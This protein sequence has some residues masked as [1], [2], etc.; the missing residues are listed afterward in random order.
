MRFNHFFS[1]TL[2]AYG[3]DLFSPFLLLWLMYEKL[4]KTFNYFCSQPNKITSLDLPCF[5]TWPW[6]VGVVLLNSLP[7]ESDSCMQFLCSGCH[8]PT[9]INNSN[10]CFKSWIAACSGLPQ[11][12]CS[13][14]ADSCDW[15]FFYIVYIMYTIYL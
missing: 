10:Q 6:E 3:K 9:F 13:G 2:M 15:N 1:R 14:I 11:K 5:L 12:R 4:S 8:C 7:N